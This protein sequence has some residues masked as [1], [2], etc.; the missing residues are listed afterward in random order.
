MFELIAIIVFIIVFINLNSKINVLSKKIDKFDPAP[1]ASVNQTSTNPVVAPTEYHEPLAPHITSTLNNISSGDS[2]INANPPV[3]VGAE[4]GSGRL[5]GGIGIA[6]VV[7][8]IS[9][10][11]KYAFENNWVGETGRVMIG[12][13]IGIGL[14]ALGQYL[15]KKYLVYSDL[16]IGGGIVVLYFSI[17]AAYTFYHLIPSGITSVLMFCIT[18]LGFAIS[19][20]D[21]TITLAM[22]SVIGGF[23]SPFLF[24]SGVNNMTTLFVYMSILNLGIL[25]ISFFKKWPQLIAVAFIGTA[26]NFF[27][28]FAGY[29]DSHA[30]APTLTFCFLSFLIFLVASVAKAITSKELT[31]NLNYFL[32]GVNAFAMAIVGYVLLDPKYHDSLGF[33]AVFIAIIY[34]A[35]AIIVNK[36]HSEDKTLNVFLPG[37]AVTFLSIAVPLQFSGPWVAVA[38]FVESAMLYLIASYISNRGFQIM[39][40][41]VYFLGIFNFFIWNMPKA[42]DINFVAIL[43]SDFAILV[44]AIGI[45]YCIAYMYKKFGSMS[46][47]IQKRGIM[48]FIIMANVLTLFAISTQ[49]IY[50]F[51][52][53]KMQLEKSFNTSVNQANLYN[54]DYNKSALQDENSKKYYS[55]RE[56]MDNRSNTYVSIIWVIYAAI[57]TFIGFNRRVISARR[58]GLVLFVITA[59]KILMD[60]WSLGQIYRIISFIVF[61]VIALGASFAYAKFKDRLNEII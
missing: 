8:G 36:F 28:W 23:T 4:E 32:L 48:V 34:M 14:I 7:I 1:K 56:S 22:I 21:A 58:L 45:A 26:I 50:H 61:G 10:F 47:D 31:D 5:L 25:G 51:N 2:P 54:T 43:N 6:A 38:W 35:V 15:R 52:T 18:A 49:V 60:V 46:L 30:L 53:E 29:Y 57:L 40:L 12:I 16:L 9:F 55:T 24:H 11:L 33:A 17:Y 20:Y 3:E 19:I 59:L 42:R 44:L 27:V 37:I 39:G 41:I 13:F